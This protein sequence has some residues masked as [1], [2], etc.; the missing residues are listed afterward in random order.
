VAGISEVLARCQANI[1]DV[2]QTIFG[3]LFVMSMLVDLA[4]ASEPLSALRTKLAARGEQLGVQV[5]VQHEKVFR[6]MHRV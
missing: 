6:Y 2:Q 3:D 1:L 4:G 5:I